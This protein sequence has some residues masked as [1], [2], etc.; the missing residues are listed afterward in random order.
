MRPDNEVNV[1]G[2]DKTVAFAAT[3][4]EPAGSDKTVI[5]TPGAAPVFEA[6][7]VGMPPAAAPSYD[8]SQK[9]EGDDA[10]GKTALISKPGAAGTPAA[11][12]GKTDPEA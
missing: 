2:A 5:M 6:T 12:D 11:S 1:G 9:S 4:N 3:A 7:V 10:F 8:A